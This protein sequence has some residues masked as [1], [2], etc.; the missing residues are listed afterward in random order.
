M[1]KKAAQG[2]WGLDSHSFVVQSPFWSMIL[3]VFRWS[4]FK[5]CSY[6]YRQ[7]WNFNFWLLW[8]KYFIFRYVKQPFSSI[9]KGYTLTVKVQQNKLF[10][11]KFKRKK[12]N[13]I[14]KE[15]LKQRL[16]KNYTTDLNCNICTQ[17]NTTLTL[18][19]LPQLQHR[20]LIKGPLQ[21]T[22]ACTTT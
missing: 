11:I 16:Y 14:T 3:L 7:Y 9:T 10:K 4:E 6:T 2:L 20:T 15:K 17:K 13:S 18:Q 1:D 12:I 21:L 22:H 19:S 8:T 5:F